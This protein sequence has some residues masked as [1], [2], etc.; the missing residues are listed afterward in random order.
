[1]S[2][3]FP[4]GEGVVVYEGETNEQAFERTRLMREHNARVAA[5][6]KRLAEW[7][8]RPWWVDVPSVK[9]GKA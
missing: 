3:Y 9:E 8:A 2:L 1:M 4:L 6:E 5:E 7:K